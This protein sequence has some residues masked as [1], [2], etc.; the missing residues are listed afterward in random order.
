MHQSTNM[1]GMVVHPKLLLDEPGDARRR[2]QIGT[3]AAGHRAFQQQLDQARFLLGLQLMGSSRGE[4]H[5][6]RLLSATLP[7]LVPAHD[8]AGPAANA[9]RRFIEG[10]TGIH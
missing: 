7:R 1:I 2:P 6:Q 5:A 4:P 8:G 10:R 3:V 9:T